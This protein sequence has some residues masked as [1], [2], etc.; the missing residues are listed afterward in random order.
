M[1]GHGSMS[2][3]IQAEDMNLN[4]TVALKFLKK[5]VKELDHDEQVEQFFREAKC[6]ASLE[7]PNIVRVHGFQQHAGRWY[8]ILEHM[9]G[10][11]LLQ[12]VARS[13]P[14]GPRRAC[15]FL[16][17][18]ASAIAEAHAAGIVHR[19]V[20]PSNLLLTR[21]GRC[22]VGDF[23]LARPSILNDE[24]RLSTLPVGSRYFLA[25][26]VAAG[27]P[28]DPSVDVYALGSTL[29]T[30]MAGRPPFPAD[31]WPELA[32]MI[33]EDA[34]P[35]IRELVPHAP[36]AVSELIVQSMSK[37]P[38][39][40][41]SALDFTSVLRGELSE[42]TEESLGSA[43]ASSAVLRGEGSGSRTSVM[44]GS[45]IVMPPA[46][47][48]ATS[49]VTP[50][51][52]PAP[53]PAKSNLTL[54]L[55][56]GLA[57][58]A[59]VAA[60]LWL[61]GGSNTVVTSPAVPSPS[62][63]QQQQVVEYSALKSR[64][65]VVFERISKVDGGQG[66]RTPIEQAAQLRGEAAG[67]FETHQA[68]AAAAKLRTM[69]ELCQRIEMLDGQRSQA[70]ARAR[71]MQVACERAKTLGASA[72][73]SSP[74]VMAAE[75]AQKA[76]QRFAEGQFQD[77]SD[78]YVKAQAQYDAAGIL[79]KS[80][81]AER[82]NAQ[83]AQQRAEAERQVRQL[84]AQAAELA[85][86]ARLN[87]DAAAVS[88]ATE[89]LDKALK[90]QPEDEACRK[91]KS[92]LATLVLRKAGDRFE[93]SIGMMLSYCPQGRFTMGSPLDE[94][95]RDEDENQVHVSLTRPFYLGRTHVTQRQWQAVMGDSYKS[96]D[97]KG[98]GSTAVGPDMPVQNISW[99]DATA[100]CKRLSVL[101]HRVYRLPTEAEWEYACRAGST[102][103]FSM[104]DDLTPA[105]AQIDGSEPYRGKTRGATPQRPQRVASFPPNAW[106][107][108]DMHGNV[109]EWCAD[110]YAPYAIGDAVDPRGPAKPESL[111]S[112][113]RVLRGGSW[114]HP[115][116]MARSAAR[117]SNSPVVKTNYIGFRVLLEAGS[118]GAESPAKP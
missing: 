35:D 57:L 52:A 63:S 109:A 70:L 19:D 20:K 68:D 94:K 69:G 79:A 61:R 65:D 17:D 27:Q 90:L 98:D 92:E 88:A 99:N 13:G 82:A 40:R 60:T 11:S 32:R 58:A 66:L 107:L 16:A 83:Q 36:R 115:A 46:P 111:E 22:K 50:V 97:G 10:G 18:A 93:N 106:N 101:E 44:S 76:Q 103:A 91:L 54:V 42:M 5:H 28:G 21:T 84:H 34:P 64:L 87:S 15:M 9:E 38:K 112:A 48:E 62:P 85:A 96:P 81:A 55:A 24:F 77:A 7:H 71:E 49:V 74:M 73:T 12:L 29:Y 39:A 31:T 26:E 67:L 95:G 104:G 14:L 89:L 2:I 102:Q 1:L 43:L 116:R 53:A 86:A 6:A 33:R 117:W 108:Y 72:E 41:P 75:L 105:M 23:G 114:C 51:A 78:G 110:W 25:P 118:V 100:F 8:L 37:N 47:S 30:V 80:Q 56:V 113:N 4:R 59:G 45:N 3:V